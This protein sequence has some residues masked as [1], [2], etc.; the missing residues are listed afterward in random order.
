[1]R[2]QSEITSDRF[3]PLFELS[4]LIQFGPFQGYLKTQTESQRKFF[5]RNS[6]IETTAY[7]PRSGLSKR[8][9]GYSGN[10]NHSD[11]DQ[12]VRLCGLE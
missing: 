11:F 6:T 1:M 3:G 8:R 2:R 10:E 4:Q 7:L 5:V 12:N 9:N